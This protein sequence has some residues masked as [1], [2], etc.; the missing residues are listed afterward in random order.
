MVDRALVDGRRCRR[1]VQ[2]SAHAVTRETRPMTLI[3]LETGRPTTRPTTRPIDH[4][5]STSDVERLPED[6]PGEHP[7]Q[8][9][10]GDRVERRR[11]R[12]NQLHGECQTR[13]QQKRWCPHCDREVPNSEI[14]KGYEFE[15]GRYV[16]MSRGGLRRRCGPSRRASSTSCSSPTT[17]SIDPMYVD[18]TVLPRAR[19]PHGA[20]TRSR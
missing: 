18:R 2:V 9:V 17:S 1:V 4:Y 14:V 12:F 13:I 16:V 6:Q 15:K 10:P 20:R 7:D 5:G 11:S 19:R 3:R 8:G